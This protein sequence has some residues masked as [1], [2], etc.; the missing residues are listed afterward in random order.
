MTEVKRRKNF[1]LS[2]RQSRHTITAAMSKSPT[3]DHHSTTL[4]PHTAYTYPTPPL[5]AFPFSKPDSHTSENY[6]LIWWWWVPTVPGVSW[7]SPGLFLIWLWSGVSA[8]VEISTT[9]R[10]ILAVAGF[11][12]WPLLR[13]QR[14]TQIQLSVPNLS[15]SRRRQTLSLPL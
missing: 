8:Q 2:V 14:S 15:A 12:T 7:G 6:L 1:E 4:G 10:I 13:C 5:P 11:R 3:G 9:V